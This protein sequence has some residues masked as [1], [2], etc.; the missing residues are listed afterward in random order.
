MI[1][2]LKIGQNALSDY[3]VVILSLKLLVVFFT[4]LTELWTRFK[5]VKK[6]V[7]ILVFLIKTTTINN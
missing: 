1:S 5:Y 6:S 4:F 7:K 3:R 2:T